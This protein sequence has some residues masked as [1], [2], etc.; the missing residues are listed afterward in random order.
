MTLQIHC[1]LV[2]MLMM[3]TKRKKRYNEMS[4]KIGLPQA[5]YSANAPVDHVTYKI[6][7]IYFIFACCI[8]PITSVVQHSQSCYTTLGLAEPLAEHATWTAEE[9]GMLRHAAVS[10]RAGRRLIVDRWDATQSPCSL[11]ALQ[12][13]GDFT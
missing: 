2:I 6:T 3:G 5:A 4:N 11:I 9:W 13:V 12:T 10:G 7:A 8:W 1:N